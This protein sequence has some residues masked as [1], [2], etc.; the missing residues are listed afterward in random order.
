MGWVFRIPH[1]TLD[2]DDRN[3]G[4]PGAGAVASDAA[5][6]LGA[7][8][9]IGAQRPRL[10]LTVVAFIAVAVLSGGLTAYGYRHLIDMQRQHARMVVE[11]H[12]DMLTEG[13]RQALSATHAL[14]AL[15]HQGRGEIA[16]FEG[17]AANLLRLYPGVSAVQLAPEGVIRLIHPLAGNE[18]AIGH[19]LLAD[20]TRNREAVLARDSR[21]LT[22]A[23]PFPLVQGGVGTVGRLPVFLPDGAGGDRFWGFTTVLIRFPEFLDRFGFRQVSEH[24]YDYVLWRRHPDSGERQVIVA[25]A[26]IPTAPTI[27]RELTIANARWILSVAPRGGW[28]DALTLGAWIVIGLVVSSLFAMVVLLMLRQR[29]YLRT[30]VADRTTALERSEARFSAVAQSAPD[31]IITVDSDGHLVGWYGGAQRMF[32]YKASEVLGQPMLLLLPERY[33]ARH[34]AGFARWRITGSETFAGGV[35]EVE[36]RRRDGSE[37]PLEISLAAWNA[38]DGRFVSGILRDISSRRSN[39][40]SLRIAA[41]AFESQEAMTVTDADARI[42]RV[43]SAFTRIT[44]YAP[45]E[46]IGRTP[47]LLKSG[48]QD[49]GFYRGMWQALGRDGFWQGE[50]WNRRNNGEVYPER[51]TISAV[52]DETGAVTHYVGT[53]SDISSEKHAQAEIEALEYFDTLTRLPNRRML[54][55]RLHQAAVV[56]A[57]RQQRGAVLLIDLDD[58]RSINDTLGHRRG[59]AMLQEVAQRLA[60][61]V[62]ESDTVARLGGDEFVV[63]IEGLV[64]KLTECAAQVEVTVDKLLA[65]LGKA[66]GINGDEVRVTPSIGITLFGAEA[67]APED[68]IKQAELAMYR[69]KEAGGNAAR[70]FDPAM[71]SAL[72]ARA[73]LDADLRRAIATEQFEL[74]FQPQMDVS[75]AVVGAEALVRWRHPQRGMVP[76][77]EFI[78]RAE[79]NGLILPLG[80]W[81]LASACACLSEWAGDPL[82]AGLSLA[83][84]VSA[85]QF[86]HVDFVAQVLALVEHHGANP[87]RL[88]L[89]LTESMLVDDIDDTAARMAELKKAGILF[90]LDDFGIGYSSL[91]YLKCLPLDQLKIDRS[92]VMDVEVDAGAATLARTIIGMGGSLGLSVIAEGVETEAQRDFLAGHGCRCF[93]GYLFSRPLAPDDFN[94]FLQSRPIQPQSTDIS[95]ES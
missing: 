50:L 72:T 62:R 91:A 43:N 90:S 21:Q 60:G 86:R 51:L 95:G 85:R 54:L 15:L 47:A 27:D 49:A 11:D 42:L 6:A 57:R 44:G 65:T 19:D 37:V 29:D 94:N 7:S 82:R 69:A 70:F 58:F 89:E 40:E 76:P 25:S 71:E 88:K 17:V 34:E 38:Q 8:P 18:R 2:S 32:G 35:V 83:V 73:A 67:D 93:Q 80:T 5:K 74:H 64:D 13:M 10:F 22:L 4:P 78:P 59:D 87:A 20:S 77:M 45:D 31:A 46:V 79:E 26:V 92:F 48:R 55:D 16:D 12:I 56:A 36:G 61:A 30:T 68:L 52:K 3:S 66:S 14:A 24:G 33:R 28:G 9:A 53:F 41:T 81:V 84:N 23:G 39:E 63:L 75:G 1:M